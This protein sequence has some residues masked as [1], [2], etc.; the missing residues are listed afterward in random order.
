M[1]EAERVEASLLEP[2]RLVE[3]ALELGRV[4]LEL[5][6]ERVVVPDLA[7]DLGQAKLRVVDV[8]I[9]AS[10]SV[11][12]RNA[13]E[14]SESFQIWLRM[15]CEL[16]RSYSTNP[17]PSRSAGPSIQ[18]SARR[19]ASSSSSGSAGSSVQRQSSESRTRKRGVASAVP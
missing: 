8:A 18:A 7:C 1:V 19:A 5:L 11:P 16:R 3:T 4:L 2:E 15:P 9:G 10:A 6:G 14:S 12:S 17:S 13:I